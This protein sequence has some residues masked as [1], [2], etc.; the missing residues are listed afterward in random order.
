M[1]GRQKTSL[2]ESRVWASLT[3]QVAHPITI[4]PH[5]LFKATWEPHEDS[6]TSLASRGLMC[7]DVVEL[8]KDS[9]G[10]PM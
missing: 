5:L 6:T 2:L 10:R 9:T 7:A 8:G 1:H 4:I 3:L